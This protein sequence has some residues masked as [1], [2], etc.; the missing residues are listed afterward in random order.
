MLS[1]AEKCRL[2]QLLAQDEDHVEAEVILLHVLLPRVEQRFTSQQDACSGSVVLTT[3]ES[4]AFSFTAADQT[5]LRHIDTYVQSSHLYKSLCICM[6]VVSDSTCK[7]FL[8]YSQL[9]ALNHCVEPQ[10]V[11][12]STTKLSQSYSSPE[13][14]SQ[15]LMEID[16]KLTIL[17]SSD[18]PSEPQVRC[19]VYMYMY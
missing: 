3:A 17:H 12:L 15:R 10:S 2:E 16:E 13:L 14:E 19:C 8:Y 4:N 1:E 7:L 11:S 6:Y 9:Q 18:S 5:A